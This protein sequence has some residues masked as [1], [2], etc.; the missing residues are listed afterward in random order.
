[1]G[2]RSSDQVPILALQLI[3]VFASVQALPVYSLQY[4]P[5]DGME[6]QLATIAVG[7]QL[8]PWHV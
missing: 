5:S 2:H 7:L 3:M 1:V 6:A 8:P 4:F